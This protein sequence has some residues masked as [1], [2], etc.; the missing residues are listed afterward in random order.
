MLYRGNSSYVEGTKN[1]NLRMESESFLTPE[2]L[3]A[4]DS[5]REWIT[6]QSTDPD[7]FWGKWMAGS[8]VNEQLVEQAVLILRGLP[9][10]FQERPVDT[11]IID[12]E[13]ES[14]QGR[15]EA[16]SVQPVPALKK[17][18]SRRPRMLFP[19]W[20]KIAAS[21]ALL[22]FFSY[23]LY[24]S[25]LNPTIEH[26]TLYGQ[27]VSF[28]LP[29]SSVVELNANSTLAYRKRNPRKVW[30]DGEA[31]FQ[32][33][34]KPGS[35]ANFEV[36]T[37]DL[38]VEVLGT[39]F[40]VASS[41]LRTEV[42]LEEGSVKLNLNRDFER[43]IYLEPGD[44]VAFEANS[45]TSLIKEKVKPKLV[46]SWKN[47]VLQFEDVS[48]SS[49]MLRIEEIYGWES[50]YLN[51]DLKNRKISVPLPAND[52]NSALILLSKAIGVEIERNEVEKTLTLQ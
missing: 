52:L 19:R 33:K 49:V 7:E 26:K 43:E 8:P 4:N 35:G 28:T 22:V 30:L 40:N 50:T 27:Q 14:L 47:G 20:S 39:A 21:V 15:I 31:F 36:V 16:S 5:F 6:G 2:D 10:D 46:S 45:S 48:L 25:V 13:W 41:G 17:P 1:I 38:I 23:F 42:V 34:K 44:L 3:L 12:G 24:E 9:F 51:E 37:N 11:A 18:I 29:D 32:V